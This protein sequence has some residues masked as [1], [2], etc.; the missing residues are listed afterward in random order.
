MDAGIRIKMGP[1]L[2]PE[3]LVDRN[4]TFADHSGRAVY[5]MKCLRP[6]EHWDWGFESHSMHGCLFVFILFLC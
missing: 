5:G 6:L 2:Y 4:Y 1:Q 3:G